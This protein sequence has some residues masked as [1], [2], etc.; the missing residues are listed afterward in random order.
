MV[1]CMFN[2]FMKDLKDITSNPEKIIKINITNGEY[3]CRVLGNGGKNVIAFH[4]FGQD[5]SAFL[6]VAIKNPSFTIYS[7]DLPFHG[8]TI[9]HNPSLCLGPQ[10]VIEI[11]QKLIAFMEIDRF[12]LIGFSIGS[13]LIYPVLEHFYSTIEN[14]WLLAPDGISENYWY[15]IATG[16]RLMRYLFQGLLNNYQI[17][18]RLGNGIL[19]INLIDRETLSF[20][21]KSINTQEKRARVFQ[22]WT[23]LRKVKLFP[24]KTTIMLN[25]TKINFYFVIGERD[26]IIPQ[27]KIE[28]LAQKMSSSKIIVLACGHHRIIEFFANWSCKYYE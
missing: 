2:W 19:S 20:A 17:L 5:G 8:E 12:S 9:I 24:G 28:P 27:S 6:P 4:G 1:D 25:K 23:Y 22:I 16:S 13:K 10:E 26:T 18:K 21:L 3:C 15:R 11:L 7:F 14:V